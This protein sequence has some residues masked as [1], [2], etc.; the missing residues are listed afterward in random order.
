MTGD[1][2]RAMRACPQPII[3]AVD[4]ICAGA[5]AMIALASDFRLATPAA[6]TAFLFVRVGLAGC[7]MGACTLLPRLIGQGRAAELLYTGRPFDRG[8]GRAHRILQLHRAGGRTCGSPRRNL[9]A[10]S[11]PGRRFAHA[12]T[13]KML[14]LEWNMGVNEALDA[15]A[16]RR[17]ACMKSN[18]FR[19]AYR[20][21]RGKAQAGI[22]GRLMNSHDD[23]MQWPF[24]DESHRRLATEASR[25][26]S[27]SLDAG[28][29]P[30]DRA[31]VDAR[32]RELVGKAWQ[33]GPS[34]A[35]PA[36]RGRRRR[37][38]FRCALASA[39]CARSW[40]ST[41]A[42]R[43]SRSRCRA[44]A[45]RRSRSLAASACARSWL[46]RVA[47]G[48]AIAAFALS[49]PEAG[50]DVAAMQTSARP[51]GDSYVLNGSKTWISNGGIAD[52]Y[53]VFARTAPSNPRADGS[54]S[55]DGI[56]GLRRRAGRIAGFS[57]A[58]R[59]DAMAPHPLARINFDACRIPAERRIGA[60]GEGFK[61]A[62][63]TLDVFRTSVA[64]AACGFARRALDEALA[65]TPRSA[66]CSAGSSPTSS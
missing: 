7:D 1:L 18:D 52:F 43:T 57:V 50:S 8:R 64:A 21:V 5:G 36:R 40:R 55:A 6:K 49:E 16:A 58:E 41:T 14:H 48:K 46:P 28:A 51:D 66:R 4:G 22:R 59:I 13:K 29:H 62:M 65:H 19:R 61:L 10:G 9:R 27:A 44:S 30:T 17:R 33:G 38:G 42:S 15:E 20:G 39:C 12:L 25:W 23:R 34:A 11:R 56:S 35:L 60:E 31:A 2:V 32:C 3:A 53:C 37:G 26:A 24:F 63:R 54:V 45:A 47:E